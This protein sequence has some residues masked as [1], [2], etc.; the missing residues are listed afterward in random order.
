MNDRLE[1]VRAEIRKTEA[2]LT[3][4]LAEIQERQASGT[5]IGNL[6]EQADYL[7]KYLV[8]LF[9]ELGALQSGVDDPAKRAA[10]DEARSKVEGD[11]GATGVGGWVVAAAV[12]LGI[13]GIVW[14]IRRNK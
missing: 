14:A 2:D 5:S 9:D 1:W 8:A 13:G 7:G 12:A 10:T 4:K 6:W 11:S 3:A